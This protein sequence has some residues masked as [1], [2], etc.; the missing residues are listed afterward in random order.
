MAEPSTNGQSALERLRQL[1]EERQQILETAK[2]EALEQANNALEALNSL[3]FNYRL[4]EGSA[5]QRKSSGDGSH[6]GTR[7]VNSDR[8]CPIC[9]FKTEPPHDARRHRA[10]AEKKPFTD[11]ELEANHIRRVG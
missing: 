6:R 5:P 11:E 8:A 3:G 10:Q 9:G 4:V 1:D 7:Q 2:S